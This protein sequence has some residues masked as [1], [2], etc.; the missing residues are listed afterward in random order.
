MHL[1]SGSY[2]NQFLGA[3]HEFESYRHAP[4]ASWR[5]GTSI[6]PRSAAVHFGDSDCARSSRACVR[7][8]HGGAASNPGAKRCR[9][10]VGPGPGCDGRPAG[11]LGADHGDRHTARGTNLR[12]A[13]VGG[14]DRCGRD[15]ERSAA[16]EPFGVPGSRT[17]H[18][19]R[20][21]PELLAGPAD[22]LARLR[23]ASRVRRARGASLP[24]WH[25]GHDARRTRPVGQFQPA[26]RTAD[27]G[28]PRTVLRAL[29]QCVRRGHLGV[30]RGPARDAAPDP[31]RGRRQL[32]HVDLRHQDRGYRGWR[33]LCGRRERIPHR[34]LSR[35][36]AG[37]ARP[38]Q[39]QARVRRRARHPRHADRQF[40]IPAGD[41]GSCRAHPGRMERKP[42]RGRS[43]GDRLQ[44]AQD[45]QPGS[46]WRRSGPH[47]QRRAATA[48]RRLRWPAPDPPV[49]GFLRSGIDVVRGRSRCRPGFRRRRRA[50]RLAYAGTRPAAD[51]DPRWRYGPRARPAHGLRQQQ[52]SDGRFAA[53]R[54][55]CRAEP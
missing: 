25:P 16:G 35:S 53:R 18:I 7:G 15:S 1:R 2:P 36:F 14:R 6:E 21:P 8:G 32:R 10:G 30:H 5:R 55:R 40:A 46:G 23:C 43:L 29:R 28:P 4:T 33:G 22:Q 9:V 51:P 54:G 52:R 44:H 34:R 24:G 47:V 42:A 49:P 48:C 37:Q 41:A 17:W 27:R 11:H 26:I 38:D 39:C 19:R 3:E 12:C 13:G 20:E 45:D 31:E 50:A